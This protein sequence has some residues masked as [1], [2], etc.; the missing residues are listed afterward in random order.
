MYHKHQK[1]TT[2]QIYSMKKKFMKLVLR[3]NSVIK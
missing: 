1:I 2:L 3:L